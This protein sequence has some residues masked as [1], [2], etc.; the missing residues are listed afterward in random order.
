[1]TI[2]Q[3][4]KALEKRIQQLESAKPQKEKK[5]RKARPPTE[6]QEFVKKQMVFVI[7]NHQ[8][9]APKERMRFIAK[10]WKERE[11]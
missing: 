3:E 9:V 6:Y 4:L 10:M 1:M 11:T 2:E 5:E 7:E 8:E